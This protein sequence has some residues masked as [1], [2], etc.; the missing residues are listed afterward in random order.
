MKLSL[1]EFFFCL[2]ST[3]KDHF[4]IESYFHFRFFIPREAQSAGF[5]LVGKCL[6]QGAGKMSCILVIL[7]LTSVFHFSGVWAGQDKTNVYSDHTKNSI[8][9]NE[10]LMKLF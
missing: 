1:R 6:Q 10:D 2:A 9:K 4:T 5:S 3:K 8:Q 7:F